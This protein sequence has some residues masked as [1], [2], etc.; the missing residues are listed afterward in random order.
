MLRTVARVEQRPWLLLGLVFLA[1]WFFGFLLQAAGSAWLRWHSDPIATTYRTTLSYTSA[2]VGDGLLIPLANVF[3]VSQLA[4]WRRPPH[5]AEV[6]GAVL[7]AGVITGF[8]HLYQAANALLNWTMTQPY[9]WTT[10]GY[11]HAAFMWAEISL[12]LFFWGQVALVARET[13][14]AVVSH[15]VFVVLLCGLA[16]LRLVFAD[17]GYLN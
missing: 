11:E 13:P 1:T 16:F 10:L 9:R 3:I 14:R 8:V 5:F 6:A 2:V 15:R 17:Y 7:F 12:V 4:R